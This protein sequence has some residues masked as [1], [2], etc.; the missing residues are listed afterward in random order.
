MNRKELFGNIVK[1][2]LIGFVLGV[3]VGTLIEI[4]VSLCVNEDTL[5]F[6]TTL[7]ERTGSPLIAFAVQTIL[8]GLFGALSFVPIIVYDMENIGL[9]WATMIHWAVIVMGFIPVSVYLGYSASVK[10]VVLMAGYQTLAF[11][12]IWLIMSAKY[13]AEVNELNRLLQNCD[14]AGRV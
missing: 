11:V 7:L 13:R 12:G 4:V 5:L 10:E 2:A 8:L 9:L 1:L 6:T 3:T 14:P